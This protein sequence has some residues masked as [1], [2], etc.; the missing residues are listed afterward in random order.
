MNKRINQLKYAEWNEISSSYILAILP[1]LPNEMEKKFNLI[2]ENKKDD[3][4]DLKI[5]VME[6][7]G[8]AS[9]ILRIFAVE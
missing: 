6:I 3:L 5:C 7:K 4:G 1:Y 9:L 8:S 2:F